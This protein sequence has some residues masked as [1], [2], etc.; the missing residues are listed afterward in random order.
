[1]LLISLYRKFQN[2]NY[3]KSIKIS[4]KPDAYCRVAMCHSRN[5]TS[6][7]FLNDQSLLSEAPPRAPDIKEGPKSV[8][9]GKFVLPCCKDIVHAEC[10][11]RKCL[12]AGG[13]AGE[14]KE[15]NCTLCK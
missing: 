10:L 5:K 1:M 14:R 2:N 6:M 15:M 4:N 9:V 12:A 7:I 11:I 3:G 8:K 13:G